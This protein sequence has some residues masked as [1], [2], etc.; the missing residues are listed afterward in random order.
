VRNGPP[1]EVLE[2]EEKTLKALRLGVRGVVLEEMAPQMLVQCLRKVHAGAQWLGRRSVGRA[3]E[4]LL[5]REAGVGGFP[6]FAPA[7]DRDRPSEGI[8]KGRLLAQ[9][10]IT[11]TRTVPG[12][13]VVGTRT[14]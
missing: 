6:R 5:S 11:S 7:R 14:G 2:T 12:R 9:L 4:M 13:D 10:E 3:L 1:R 8:A